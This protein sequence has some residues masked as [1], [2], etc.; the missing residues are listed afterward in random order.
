MALLGSFTKQPAE[1]L[2]VDISYVDVI[3]GRTT[4]AIVPVITV[5]SGMT[6]VSSIVTGEVLQ[7]YLGSGT[8]GQTYRWTIRTSITI[9]GLITIVEDE[10]D[11][12]VLEV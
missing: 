5:P 12:V 1:Q 4:S 9:G 3:G 10:F 8:T 6:S 11:V 7:I 2:P